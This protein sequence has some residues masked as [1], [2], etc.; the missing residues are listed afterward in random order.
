MFIGGVMK[1]L[2]VVVILFLSALLF[3]NLFGQDKPSLSLTGQGTINNP[4]SEFYVIYDQM[5]YPGTNSITSQNFE[6]VNDIFDSFAA[7]DFALMDMTWNI[8]SIDVLGVYSNGTGPANSVNVW[9]YTCNG[10]G[11]L[12][13]DIIYSALNIIPS[14]GLV[15]GSFSIPL[16]VTAVLNE[17]WYWLCVQANMDY[18]TGGQWLWTERTFQDFSESAWKNPG[19][20]FG[21]PCT[22]SWGYRVT[23]CA[24]GTQPDN[25][26]RLNGFVTPVE[27]ISFTAQTSDNGVALN[28]STATE[29]NNQGFEVERQVGSRQSEVGNSDW[30]VIGYVPGFGTTTEPISYSYTDS[31]VLAGKY[32]Y[33]LKQID[34]DGSFKYSPEVEVEVSVPLEFV[35]E[36]NYPNPFNPSTTVKFQI[37]E[38]SFI[39]IKVF[40]ILGNEIETLVDEEKP[41]G[42]YE[43]TWNATNLP[44]GVYFYQLRSGEF[45]SMKK[46]IL[47][48]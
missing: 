20:G 41:A 42:I 4:T 7:D 27:L 47:L 21:T 35:L 25:C 22:P 3:G 32:T 26:F 37:P 33:R 40:D 12:P 17:G 30:E 1:K 5:N 14:S 45:T 38:L 2:Q 8:E 46:M 10:S 19:G 18:A 11:G 16:P 13:T 28:W 23:N 44:S 6:T 34:F 39:T 29:T 36:Q 48:R 9:I 15:D 43:L 24:V 31:E